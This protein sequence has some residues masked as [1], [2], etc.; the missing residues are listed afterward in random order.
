MSDWWAQRSARER[1]MLAVMLLIAIPIL[2]W[3]LVARPLADAKTDARAEYLSALDRNARVKAMM[4]SDAD[5]TDLALA[6]PLTQFI[7]EQASQRGF[8]LTANAQE[9]PGV[10]RIAIAQASGQALLGWLG[11]LE[12]Q[13]LVIS[14]LQIT[15]GEAGGVALSATISEAP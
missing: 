9:A 13:G 2:A 3:L 1:I 6:V 15:P 10:I 7:D 14:N 8:T 11:E 12:A 4:S 5:R